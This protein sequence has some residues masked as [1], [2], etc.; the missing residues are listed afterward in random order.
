MA[1]V[2]DF[3]ESELLDD[4]FKH[5]LVIRCQLLKDQMQLALIY[6]SDFL[7]SSQANALLEQFD[8]VLQQLRNAGEEKLSTLSVAS[9]WDVKQAIQQNMASL[10]SIEPCLNGL[11][12]I[13]AA[14]HFWIVD[15]DNHHKLAPFGCVGELVLQGHALASGYIDDSKKTTESFID[16]F[17]WLSDTQATDI[18]HF[19]KTGDLVRCNADGSIN[20]IGRKDAQVKIQGQRV[21]PCEIEAQIRLLSSQI[22]E[23]AVDVITSD[24]DESLFAFISFSDSKITSQSAVVQLVPSSNKMQEH[25]SQVFRDLATALPNHMVPKYFIPIEYMPLN[26]RGKIDKA[27]LIQTVIKLS[28]GTLGRYLTSQHPP[29][30]DCSSALEHWVRAHWAMILNI[31]ADTI[32]A[33]NNFYQLGG[34]SIQAITMF[35]LAKDNF[36]VPIERTF[37]GNHTTVSH[38][39]KLIEIAVEDEATGLCHPASGIDLLAKINSISRASWI[40]HPHALQANPITTIRDQSTVF[41]TGATGFLGTE[42]LNQL[43]R[44]PAV[45]SIIVHVRSKSIPEGMKRIRETAKIAGWWREE[46]ADKLEVWPGDLSKAHLGL[47]E[48]HRRRLS[49]LSE[50]EASINAIIHNGASVNW[51]ATYDTLCHPNVN[52]TV[53]LLMVT[54]TSPTQPKFVFVSGGAF[55][56]PDDNQAISAVFLKDATA[57]IQTKFVCE[58]VIKNITCNLPINQNRVSIVKP[59]RIVGTVEHGIANVDD[60]VWR[61]VSAAAEIKAY[62]EEPEAHWNYIQDVSSVT[63]SILNQ[64]FDS[65]IAP[66]IMSGSGMPVPVFWDLVNSELE[67]PC[68]P[69]PWSEWMKRV[70][71]S[72]GK[73]GGKHPLWTVQQFLSQLGILRNVLTYKGIEYAEYKDTQAAIKS[74]VRYLKKIGFI[75]SSENG[76]GNIEQENVIRRVHTARRSA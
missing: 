20:Y 13:Q 57:Y 45:R 24:I 67:T 48:A 4:V 21:E 54:A 16:Y 31:P 69:V 73:I 25:L 62:P 74:N 52:S 46:D 43:V 33:D 65:T 49:G 63:S 70:T 8:Y 12:S 5:P 1:A 22:K 36:N 41:L 76:F 59:G 75:S 3:T 68:K 10:Q 40:S 35:R 9:P 38:M 58:G 37:N 50:S 56:S 34:D 44:N 14:H 61:V 51:H 55:T 19:Y 26:D 32:G 39:A 15:S 11:F 18:K 2:E 7:H 64:I 27:A 71:E 53:D 72:I 17:E 66:F 60:F 42:I 28:T 30:R 6:D 47:N 29:F 23:V